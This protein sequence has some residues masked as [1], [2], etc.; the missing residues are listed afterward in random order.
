MELNPWHIGGVALS[1]GGLA[2]LVDFLFNR[3]TRNVKVLRETV[4]VLAEQQKDF[5]QSLRD[6]REGLHDCERKHRECEENRESDRRLHSAEIEAMRKQI[7]AMMDGADVPEY[8][9]QDLKRVG[10]KR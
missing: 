3:E 2:K 7:R 6:M 5:G 10:G 9:K 4:E 1:G 8:Q